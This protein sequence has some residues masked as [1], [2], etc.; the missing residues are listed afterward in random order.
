MVKTAD[1]VIA[2]GGLAGLMSALLLRRAGFS[3]ILIER[4]NYPFH[5]VCGE[6]V[7]NEVLPLL[8]RLGIDVFGLGAVPIRRL[9]ISA[10][11]GRK[12]RADL[13]LGGFGISRFTLDHHLFQLL[14]KEGAEILC[15]EKINDIRF[16][17]DGFF[18]DT[19][20]KTF[21]SRYVI[22]AF[23][24]RS[25]LDQQLGRPFFSRRSPYVG[26]KYHVKTVLP[27]DLI[28]L[29]FFRQGYCG[30]SKVE[31]GRYCLCYLVHRDALRRAGS[32]GALEQ[33]S[34]CENPV[35]RDILHHAERVWDKPEVINEIS[36]ARKAPVEDHILMCGDTA[37]MIAPL[38]GNGMAM[39]MRSADMLS[40]IIIKYGVK[41][42]ASR[43]LI[44]KEYAKSWNAEFRTRLFA[45]RLLQQLSGHYFL[46]ET[47]V[48]ILGAV[49]PVFRELVRTTH[50]K[51]P[52]PATE[53]A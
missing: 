4:R 24:K 17:G 8:E 42:A 44:E 45:G 53:H 43:T 34:L 23:G 39:A 50:G 41:K 2:G 46:T 12:I 16:T 33:T 38:C 3:V 18:V 27:D 25:N 1:I 19:A 30:I 14:G 49:P 13:P 9:E 11:S 48:A 36:F 10:Q 28:Q 6:Y 7:S 21:R 15:G 22:G 5:R 51:T 52:P 47:V 37:G 32:I 26:I 20:G 35:L 29:H 40:S 31:N